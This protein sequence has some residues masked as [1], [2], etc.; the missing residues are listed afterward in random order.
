MTASILRR[1]LTAL[2]LAVAAAAP[3]ASH[4]FEIRPMF[5][6]GADFGGDT[7][8]TVVFTD[9]SRERIKAND[10]FSLGGGAVIVP[11]TLDVEIEVSLAYKFDFI[12]AK[13]GDVDWT[14]FPF[15]VLVFHTRPEL[16]FRVGGGLTYHL[17]PKVDGSGAARNVN[18]NFDD[19]LGFVLQGEY[20]IAGRINLNAGL[21][22]TSVTY[23]A[24][25]LGSAKS[26]GLGLTFSLS[27]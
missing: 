7:L 4:A 8:V 24:S 9:G 23:K 27:F 19:A 10:G 14:R 11:D 18:I 1:S 26:N 17:S 22:Y 15:E 25:G 21:R 16:P 12:V 13:N 20:R 6:A 2:A 3:V 5:K